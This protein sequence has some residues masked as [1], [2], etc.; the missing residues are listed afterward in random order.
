[1]MKWILILV[2]TTF[3]SLDGKSQNENNHWFFGLNAG[4][5]FNSGSPQI[6]NVSPLRA[7]E[8]SSSISD[9]L[10]NLIFYTNGGGYPHFGGVWDRNHNLM[11]N[12]DLNPPPPTTW[13]SCN[14]AQMGTVIVPD[15]GNENEYYIFAADCYES[16]GGLQPMT[17]HKVD[18][19]LNSGFGDV[20]LIHQP[21]PNVGPGMSWNGEAMVA[22]S[23]SNGEDYWVVYNNPWTDAYHSI[24]V[25]DTGV[26]NNVSSIAYTNSS[27][28]YTGQMNI[29]PTGDKLCYC[30]ES[31]VYLV[32]FDR[33]TGLVSNAELIDI[34]NARPTGCAFS[35]SGEKLY[36]NFEQLNGP[37]CGGGGVISNLMYQYDLSSGSIQDNYIDFFCANLNET[38]GTMQIGPDDKIYMARKT[39]DSLGIINNPETLGVGCDFNPNGLFLDTMCYLGLPNF[40]VKLPAISTVDLESV[41]QSKYQIFPNPFTEEIKVSGNGNGEL[42]TIEV[43]DIYGNIVLR[44]SFSDIEVELSLGNLANGVYYIYIDDIAYK[45]L[46]Q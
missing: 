12:G 32:D 27:T 19:S 35:R 7:A 5:D 17:F 13:L 44:N 45:V 11:P 23:H 22:V 21:I 9:S 26:A 29:S 14:S 31:E 24:L 40:V 39:M 3:L 25:S 18:M 41:T 20:T 36:V 42:V 43:R 38:F 15:P 34:N 10:G 4:L 33:S 8:S 28:F 2:A 16:G 1:M 37:A 46:K 6:N 30:T